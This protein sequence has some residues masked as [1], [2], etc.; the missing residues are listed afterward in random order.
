MADDKTK[1]NEEDMFKGGIYPLTDLETGE[2]VNFRFLAQADLDGN[3][4]YAFVPVEEEE[5]E[6]QQFVILK[7]LSTDGDDIDLVDIESDEEFDR[8]ADYFED[9]YF[10]NIDYDEDGEGDEDAEEAT[11]YRKPLKQE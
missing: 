8:V 5:N 11:A 4:Y 1:I 6:E 2:Q 7:V 9:E 3:T 10:S